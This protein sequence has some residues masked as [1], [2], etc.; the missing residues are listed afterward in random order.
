MTR[1]RGLADNSG[2]IGVQVVRY[3]RGPQSPALTELKSP[4][5]TIT[6]SIG[7]KLKLIPAGEFLMGSSKSP[8]EPGG[9]L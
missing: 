6:N 9:A 3:K 2:K 1:M 7:M 4:A 8:E 5:D